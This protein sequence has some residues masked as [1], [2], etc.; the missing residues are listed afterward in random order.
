MGEYADMQIE[1]EIDGTFSEGWE[2]LWEPN[3]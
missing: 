2:Y 1:G 3:N